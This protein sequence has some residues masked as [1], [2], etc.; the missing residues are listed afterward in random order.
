MKLWVSPTWPWAT[1]VLSLTASFIANGTYGYLYT[2]GDDYSAQST[3][4]KRACKSVFIFPFAIDDPP[5]L[6]KKNINVGKFMQLLRD[7]FLLRAAL[8]MWT[9][10]VL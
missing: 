2:E 8:N 10:A 7:L 5:P 9:S 6:Q 3:R 1:L 4:I